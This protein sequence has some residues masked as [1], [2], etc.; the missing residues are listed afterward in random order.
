MRQLLIA[1]AIA[2]SPTPASLSAQEASTQAQ[3]AICYDCFGSPGGL[4]RTCFYSFGIGYKYC[5]SQ[6]DSGGCTC[7]QGGGLCN[8]M[9]GMLPSAVSPDGSFSAEGLPFLTAGD[10]TGGTPTTKDCQARI[11]SRTYDALA[12]AVLRQQLEVLSL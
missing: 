7:V 9:I 12:S 1:L 8:G 2:A 5:F 3:Q 6:C 10:G 4:D 11:I